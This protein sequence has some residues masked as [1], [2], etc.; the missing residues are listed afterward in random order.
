MSDRSVNENMPRTKEQNEAIRAGKRQRI[1]ESAL[2]L[3]AEDGYAHTSIDKIAKHAKISKG[4]LYTYFSSKEDLLQQ[5]LISG[6]EKIS[7]GIF[8]KEMSVQEFI[9][10]LEQTFH[11]MEVY[12]DFF[13]LYTALSVQPSVSRELSN[14]SDNYTEAGYLLQFYRQ[15][16]GENALQEILLLS[17]IIKGFSVIYLF[18]EQQTRIPLDLLKSTVLD[19]I[20]KRLAEAGK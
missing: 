9:G 11:H 19:F 5:I 8:K 6:F 1:M 10:S 14:L 7:A 3:F 18:G 4:L 15:H 16:F 17:T 13:R 2:E 12:K 20:K